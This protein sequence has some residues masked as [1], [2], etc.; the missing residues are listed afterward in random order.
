MA[1]W[2]ANCGR[3]SGGVEWRVCVCA[4]VRFDEAGRTCSSALQV[5]WIRLMTAPPGPMSLPFVPSGKDSFL[6]RGANACR[7]T[8]GSLMTT[9]SHCATHSTWVRGTSA[10]EA[11]G[12]CTSV[13]FECGVRVR[14]CVSVAGVC[15]EWGRFM[16]R[17]DQQV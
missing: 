9:R 16:A 8:R 10:Q 5:A 14:V 2:V 6:Y 7:S 11:G 15:L 17:A 13:I 3:V 1:V 4:S 12:R